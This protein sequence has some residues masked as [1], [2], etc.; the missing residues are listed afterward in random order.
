MTASQY[1]AIAGDY[2]AIKDSDPA[3]RIAIFPT[4]FDQFGDVR[5][6]SIAEFFCGEGR[7]GRALL[8]RGAG[9][10]VGIDKDPAMLAVAR[11]RQV[12]HTE[13]RQGTVGQLG[14]IGLFN[15]I[16]CP[17]AFHYAE[18]APELF[19]MFRD[20]AVNL[21]RGGVC[22]VLNNNPER[23]LGGTVRT[24]CTSRSDD[25]PLVDG[26]PIIVTIYGKGK[27]AS[28]TTHHWSLETYQAAARA[29]GLSLMLVPFRITHE[30]RTQMGED[31]CR[32]FETNICSCIFVCRHL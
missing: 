24:G 32:E 5:G 15:A 18:T 12:A 20:A 7:A 11:Q 19:S 6:Q 13:Y 10:I 16:A 1:T 28:F 3:D 23:T 17:W 8:A 4:F 14:Q 21:K 26:S 30:G 2:I 9:H 31:W 25:D 27:S 22:V 29:A